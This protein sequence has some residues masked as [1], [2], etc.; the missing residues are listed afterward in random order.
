MEAIEF[1]NPYTRVS[2]SFP[3]EK[4]KRAVE[5]VIT[6]AGVGDLDDALFN[7]WQISAI[8][9]EE[10]RE[11]LSLAQ[12]IVSGTKDGFIRP[13]DFDVY[14]LAREIAGSIES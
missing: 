11:L 6:T 12:T 7:C 4:V 5:F 10:E 1:F 14:K 3:F 13:E 2:L 9:S 8:F